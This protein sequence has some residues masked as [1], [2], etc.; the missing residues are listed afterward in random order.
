MIPQGGGLRPPPPWGILAFSRNREIRISSDRLGKGFFLIFWKSVQNQKSCIF[1][2]PGGHNKKSDKIGAPILSVRSVGVK[3]VGVNLPP[4]RFSLGVS[5]LVQGFIG[6]PTTF[7]FWV[8]FSS[9]LQVSKQNN[10]KMIFPGGSCHRKR[11][12]LL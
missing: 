8:S 9:S 12:L 5:W 7:M 11:W 2:S 3:S 1:W 6:F 4:T 10:T